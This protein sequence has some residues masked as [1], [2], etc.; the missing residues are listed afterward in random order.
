MKRLSIKLKLTL[1]FAVAMVLLAGVF[2][3]FITVVSN[4]T[5]VRD[6]R[7]TLQRV[8]EDNVKEVEY[9]DGKLDIDDDFRYYRDNIYSAVFDEHGTL[10]IGRAPDDELLQQAFEDGNIREV[11]TLN[12]RYYVYDRLLTF[13]RNPSVWVRGITSSGGVISS[14]TLSMV[15]LTALPLLMLLAVTGGYTIA[16]RSLYPIRRINETMEEVGRSGDLSRRIEI[17]S[18]DELGQLAG[19]FNRMLDRL[20]ASFEAERQ[21]T[22]DASHELRTPVSVILAQCEY[23]FE[24]ASGE[25]ELYECIGAVQKQGYRMSRLIESLLAFARLEQNEEAFVPETTDLSL[26]VEQIC[27]DQIPEKGISL[28]CNV[29]PGVKAEVDRTLFSRMFSNLLQNACRYGKENGFIE[30]SLSQD[31]HT[32]VLSVTDDG[33]GIAPEEIPKIWNRFYRVDKAR[34]SRNE[35]LGLG[36]SMVRQIVEIHKGRVDVKSVL[37]VGSTFNVYMPKSQTSQ[38]K[39]GF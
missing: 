17:G 21:F 16:K 31:D 27:E 1:W 37:G 10:I 12:G 35:G 26:L 28:D 34:S 30:V 15:A 33:I 9:D 18:E 8:V 19:T 29:E 32:I 13:R 5:A 4:S 6:A 7:K 39:R 22:S 23:A 11:T 2:F 3:A 14:T 24:N 36:L 20:E 25:E 38:T